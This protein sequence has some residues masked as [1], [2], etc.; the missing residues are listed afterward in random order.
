MIPHT[1]IQTLL[2]SICQDLRTASSTKV[3]LPLPYG[4]LVAT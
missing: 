1:Q 2:A 3:L 4:A